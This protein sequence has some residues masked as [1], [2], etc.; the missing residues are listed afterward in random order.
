MIFDSLHT[1]LSVNLDRDG[2]CGG[3]LRMVI[4]TLRKTM[5][6][7]APATIAPS[8]IKRAYNGPTTNSI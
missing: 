7:T 5:I 2:C 3:L 4:G 8:M 6:E 1:E